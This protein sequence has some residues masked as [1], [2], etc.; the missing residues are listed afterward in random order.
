MMHQFRLSHHNPWMQWTIV[1]HL[2]YRNNILYSLI[3]YFC[4][5][6]TELTNHSNFK[7]HRKITKIQS[8]GC[9]ALKLKFNIDR[10]KKRFQF[11]SPSNFDVFLCIHFSRVPGSP[12][13]I[14][15]EFLSFWSFFSVRQRWWYS[16]WKQVWNGHIRYYIL[17]WFLLYRHRSIIVVFI[18]YPFLWRWCGYSRLILHVIW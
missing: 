6:R 2:F 13:R 15:V 9:S 3:H 8:E 4:S 16:R 5:K 18:W 12:F 11:P 10:E 1:R 7:N 17:H 14:F